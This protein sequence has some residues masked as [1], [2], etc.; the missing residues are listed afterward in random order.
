MYVSTV[1]MGSVERERIIVF[2]PL[3]VKD[4]R[5]CNMGVEEIVGDMSKPCS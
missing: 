1:E 2:V 3:I 4:E 5:I